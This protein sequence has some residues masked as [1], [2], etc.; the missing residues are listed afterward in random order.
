MRDWANPAPARS[1]SQVGSTIVGHYRLFDQQHAGTDFENPNIVKQRSEV[2]RRTFDDLFGKW[3]TATD[4]INGKKLKYKS[5]SRIGLD[6]TRALA[7]LH[8]AIHLFDFNDKDFSANGK[9]PFGLQDFI[10]KSC[11]N[12]NYDHNDT[13]F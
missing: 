13:A 12:A 11:I 1:H 5:G 4:R 9:D 3:S 2:Q 10:I 8:E 7:L 6:Q